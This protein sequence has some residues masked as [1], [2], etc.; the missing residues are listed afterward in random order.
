MILKPL[1][2]QTNSKWNLIETVWDTLYNSK[3]LA[4]WEF[5]GRFQRW[6][7]NCFFK[8]L[9]FLPVEMKRNYPVTLGG[10][11]LVKADNSW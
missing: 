2:S 5:E 8:Y 4:E 6:Q 1:K 3:A 10:R 7:L 11:Y 9:R